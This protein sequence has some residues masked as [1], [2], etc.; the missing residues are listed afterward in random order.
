M[1]KS[2]KYYKSRAVNVTSEVGLTTNRDLAEHSCLR[3]TASFIPPRYRK[4][5][6]TCHYTSIS[7]VI[8]TLRTIP[9]RLVKRLEDLE[10]RVQVG[11]L[12]NYR[13][14]IDQYTEKSPG[15]LRKLTITKTPVKDHQL[16]LV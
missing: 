14:K 13:I 11:K 12:Q 7:N 6:G 9:R 8:G 3:N 16:T 1:V 10:I 15:D 5:C 2:N 4:S